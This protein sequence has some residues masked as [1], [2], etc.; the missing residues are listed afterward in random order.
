M[1]RTAEAILRDNAV[2]GD[3]NLLTRWSHEPGRSGRES[4]APSESHSQ[5]VS[6]LAT[7]W[8]ARYLIQLGRETGQGR[9]WNRALAMLDGIL[10]RLLPARPGDCGP[11]LARERR[12]ADSSSGV[13]S[14]VWGLHAMLD[15]DHARLRRARLRRPRPPPDARPGPAR[16][17]APHRA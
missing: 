2:G 1:V 14:G 13:A 17:L 9:H 5:D 11:A 7:L 16:G 10:G 4:F 3:P 8:M 12:S 6:S 15:R